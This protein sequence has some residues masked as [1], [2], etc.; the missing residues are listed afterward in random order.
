MAFKLPKFTKKSHRNL[1]IGSF[2]SIPFLSSIISTLHI[3]RFFLLG[4]PEM[5]AVVLAITYEVGSLASMMS[6]SVLHKV[7]KAPIYFIFFLLFV[8]QLAGNLYFSYDYV[9]TQMLND[10]TWLTN[11]RDLVSF[12][13]GETPD[14]KLTKFVLSCVIGL[15]IPLI[16]LAF[17]KSLVDY[18]DADELESEDKKV[19]VSEELLNIEDKEGL[20]ESEIE[21]FK[22]SKVPYFEKNTN[23]GINAEKE[24]TENKKITINVGNK[25]SEEVQEDL[26][27][28]LNSYKEEPSPEIPFIEPKREEIVNGPYD[29]EQTT[30]P[31]TVIIPSKNIPQ[32][33]SNQGI[34]DSIIHEKEPKPEQNKDNTE[35]NTKKDD[36]KEGGLKIAVFPNNKNI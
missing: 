30:K 17:T 34:I 36:D 29:Y 10:P 27:Q 11:F 3:V 23:Y 24:L 19:E 35:I 14:A 8:L 12:F 32:N 25:T 2:L 33:I 9:S 20:D 6:F 28:L 31:T 4:N 13:L 21:N 18:L 16:S 5:M 1:V 15:P 26:K 22:S 7:K